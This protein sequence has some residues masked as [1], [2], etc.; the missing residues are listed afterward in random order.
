M[1]H[2]PDDEDIV[3]EDMRRKP[4][5]RAMGLFQQMARALR[6]ANSRMP[7]TTEFLRERGMTHID[8]LDDEGRRQLIEYLR[9]HFREGQER[10]RRGG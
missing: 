10:H 5:E 7:A 6:D 8:E 2:M 4:G 9:R 3:I 1:T